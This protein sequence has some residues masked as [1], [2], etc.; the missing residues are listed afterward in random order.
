MAGLLSLFYRVPRSFPTGL[1][2]FDTAAGTLLDPGTSVRMIYL[3]AKIAIERFR[4]S[5]HRPIIAIVLRKATIPATSR[6]NPSE[7]GILISCYP[8]VD[9]RSPF[10]VLGSLLTAIPARRFEQA[11]FGRVPCNINYDGKLRQCRFDGGNA[12]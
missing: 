3:L 1:L 10:S 6:R 9:S 5:L 11:S 4:L 12:L 2:S 8:P 7:I